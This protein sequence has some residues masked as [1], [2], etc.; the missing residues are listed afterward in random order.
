VNRVKGVNGQGDTEGVPKMNKENNKEEI[1]TINEVAEEL[2]C[3]KAHVYKTIR[4]LVPNVRPLPVISMGRRK[5][6][7]RSSLED[8]IQANEQGSEEAN[9]RT[10]GQPSGQSIPTRPGAIVLGSPEVNAARRMK[11]NGHA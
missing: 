1:L 9:E 7:R 2:C 3:S 11:G 5:L 4:G 6:V 8:W 10:N